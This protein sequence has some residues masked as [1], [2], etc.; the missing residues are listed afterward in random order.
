MSLLQ[1]EAEPLDE[2]EKNEQMLL[3]IKG[4]AESGVKIDDT[5]LAE[6]YEELNDWLKAQPNRK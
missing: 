2:L 6:Q 1:A 3:Y 5:L 4:L